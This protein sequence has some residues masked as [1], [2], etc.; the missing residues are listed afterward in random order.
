VPWESPARVQFWIQHK[1]DG[2]K[3]RVDLFFKSEGH[4]HYYRIIIEISKKVD[5]L[6]YFRF[7]S[8]SA[9]WKIIFLNC[10][11]ALNTLFFYYFYLNNCWAWSS[12]FPKRKGR[13]DPRQAAGV[14]CAKSATEVASGCSQHETLLSTNTSRWVP[15][16]SNGTS[17][18]FWVLTKVTDADLVSLKMAYLALLLQVNLRLAKRTAELGTV[19]RAVRQNCAQEYFR[20]SWSS[21]YLICLICSSGLETKLS[22]RKRQGKTSLCL[23]GSTICTADT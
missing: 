14:P 16:S 4:S 18:R 22:T 10:A 12:L 17:P 21:Q 2:G 3:E 6:T 1:H 9:Y 15:K 11:K 5:W 23:L 8:L 19:T 20:K 7:L 13:L